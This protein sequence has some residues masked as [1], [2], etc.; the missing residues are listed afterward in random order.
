MNKK[1]IPSAL[2]LY[3]NY[4]LH[5]VGCSVLGQAVIKESLGNHCNLCGVRSWTSDCTS[6]CRAAV[7]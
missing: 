2:V 7:R 4:F 3:L 1:Y 6:L 5:G